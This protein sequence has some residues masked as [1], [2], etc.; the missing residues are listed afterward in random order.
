[1][2]AGIA[3]LIGTAIGTGGTL[4]STWLAGRYQ[5]RTQYAQWRRQGRRD[6]Y[7]ALI[8]AVTAH[9]EA[10]DSL[11]RLLDDT[12]SPDDASRA[13]E[14]LNRLLPAVR[15]AAPVVAVEGPAD[16]S[17]LAQDMTHGAMELTS[18]I[19]YYVTA[20]Q[21]FDGPVQS[22]A[23]RVNERLLDLNGQLGKFTEQAST[24]LNS[25]K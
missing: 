24:A 2:D 1:M 16:V 15:A 12:Y 21:R 8:A 4:G 19:D 11:M 7:S 14:H 18:D 10:A 3:A 20:A 9:R 23:N 22:D 17:A 6:A 25:Q 13:L 5:G